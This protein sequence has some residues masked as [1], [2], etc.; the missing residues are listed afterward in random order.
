MILILMALEDCMMESL[1][2]LIGQNLEIFYRK[3]VDMKHYH[4]IFVE[5]LESWI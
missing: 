3:V 1:L 2:F 5:K 4:D